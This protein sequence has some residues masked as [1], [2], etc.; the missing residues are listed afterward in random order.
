MKVDTFYLPDGYDQWYAFTPQHWYQR[1]T[2]ESCMT[3]VA[4]DIELSDNPFDEREIV[5]ALVN[6]IMSN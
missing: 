5:N 6:K 3:G 2:E 1:N 4:A